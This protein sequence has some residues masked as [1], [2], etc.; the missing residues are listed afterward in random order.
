[1]RINYVAVKYF[2][3]TYRD[4]DKNIESPRVGVR[5]MGYQVW[6]RESPRVGA[7]V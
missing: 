1:M 4:S 2:R 7:A 6:R 3:V 5:S